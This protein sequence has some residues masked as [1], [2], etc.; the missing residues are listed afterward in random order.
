MSRKKWN[1]D[2]FLST[3]KRH[4]IDF[5][6]QALLHPYPK[7]KDEAGKLYPVL[8][9][10]HDSLA[11][12]VES[13]TK[14]EVLNFLARFDIRDGES[15]SAIP[16]VRTIITSGDYDFIRYVA[17]IAAVKDSIKTALSMDSSNFF[18]GEIT[19]K[20]LG[21]L[22]ENNLMSVYLD[23]LLEMAYL[24]HSLTSKVW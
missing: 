9:R 24:E 12:E 17:P 10:M 15:S 1:P 6:Q 2:S 8:N 13:M 11:S 3:L 19:I 22:E 23:G 14:N 7:D 5:R 16:M 18:V 20:Y 21:V 4:A